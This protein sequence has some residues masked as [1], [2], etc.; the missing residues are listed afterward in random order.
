MI[1]QNFAYK[2]CIHKNRKSRKLKQM[3][4]SKNIKHG[5][6]VVRETILLNNYNFSMHYNDQIEKHYKTFTCHLNLM[7]AKQKK[8][9]ILKYFY[10]RVLSID[11]VKSERHQFLL[12]RDWMERY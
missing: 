1:M 9:E 3:I 6:Q 8:L 4:S 5:K 12:P 10:K 7:T 2:Y 11:S